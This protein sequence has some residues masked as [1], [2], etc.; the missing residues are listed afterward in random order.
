MSTSNNR[1]NQVWTQLGADIDGEATLDES[2]SSVSLSADGQVM[3]VA[4]IYN[5][6]NGNGNECGHVR[7]YQNNNGTWTQIGSDIDGE[8]AGDDSGFAVSL[9]ADGQVVAIGAIGNDGNGD[10][11]GHVRVYKNNNDTWV[12]L[13]SDID[14]EAVNDLS[15]S[16][17]S[18]S[19]N[20]QIVAIGA[21]ENDGNGNASGQVRVYH[22]ESSTAST[23]DV[24]ITQ[25][26]VLYPNPT[27][28]RL[29]I[30]VDA[31]INI[32][33]IQVYDQI[34]KRVK[35]IKTLESSISLKGLPKGVYHAKFKTNIG[36]GVKRIVKN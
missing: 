21:P 2:G 1:S 4:A 27:K 14:G 20:G 18:L 6:G 5:T 35:L 10:K 17:V 16:S 9:S 30:Q 29:F 3:A 15:G 13:G 33:E 11:S 7:M 28:E 25:S 23:E 22:L 19:S 8:A 12:Q 24:F 36:T 26:I 32:E 34:G 31:G